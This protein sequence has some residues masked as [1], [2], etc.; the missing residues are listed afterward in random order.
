[1]AG[2]APPWWFASFVFPISIEPVYVV[3][4]LA[5]RFARQVVVQSR[6]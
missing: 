2:R 6:G 4:V 5:L 1:M 3:T